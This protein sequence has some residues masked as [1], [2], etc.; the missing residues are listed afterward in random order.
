MVTT[1]QNV[2]RPGQKDGQTDRRRDRLINVPNE[3]G[4]FRS[5]VSF[6]LHCV[7]VPQKSLFAA[8]CNTAECSPLRYE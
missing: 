4:R 7:T 6:A 1:M 3:V 2:E 5:E 8:A